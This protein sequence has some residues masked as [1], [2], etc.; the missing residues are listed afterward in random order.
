MVASTIEG[1]ASVVTAE[2]QSASELSQGAMKVGE[3]VSFR[4][5][6][7]ASCSVADGGEKRVLAGAE[8]VPARIGGEAGKYATPHV[9]DSKCYGL[10]RHPVAKKA[11][12]RR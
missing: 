2:S 3:A 11:L 8:L 5:V 4:E 1:E 10:F 6:R 9:R 7:A 12:R